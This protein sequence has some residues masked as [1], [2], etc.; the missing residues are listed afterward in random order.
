MKFNLH[1]I[2]DA[3]YVLFLSIMVANY[4]VGFYLGNISSLP[5]IP[6][7]TYT[8]AAICGALA[9]FFFKSVRKAFYASVATAVLACF[10][11][12]IVLF[13]PAYVG[14]I[15]TEV[16]IY[17]ALWVTVQMFLY[18][19]PMAIGGCMVAAFLYPD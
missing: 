4:W 11:T 13:M 7:L 3:V 16:G 1:T 10:I 9:Y 17:L 18:I 5:L 8:M 15:D 19:F 14:I 6:F 2:W 12:G